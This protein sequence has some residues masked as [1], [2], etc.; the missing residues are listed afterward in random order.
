MK[1]QEVVRGLFYLEEKM[2]RQDE[3]RVQI[4]NRLAGL[5]EERKMW[6]EAGRLYLSVGMWGRGVRAYEEAVRV[7]SV[8]LGQLEKAA[9]TL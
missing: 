1:C 8:T 9:E 4:A 7:G 5:A 2:G 3:K 6:K